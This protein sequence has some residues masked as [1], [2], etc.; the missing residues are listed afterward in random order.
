MNS[1]SQQTTVVLSESQVISLRAALEAACQQWGFDVRA[2]S[3]AAETSA[4]GDAQR[5]YAALGQV[6]LGNKNPNA[7]KNCAWKMVLA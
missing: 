7:I 4:A 1:Y 6:R 5:L 3:Q 2:A